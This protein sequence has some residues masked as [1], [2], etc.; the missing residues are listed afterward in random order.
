[1]FFSLLKKAFRF[2]FIAL[3]S[4]T[5][6]LTWTPASLGQFPF[7]SPSVAQGIPQ[8]PRWAPNKAQPCGNFWCSEV[9]FYGNNKIRGGL[10]LGAFIRNPDNPQKTPQETAFDLEQRAR[11]VQ[12]IFEEMF[13]K[14]VRSNPE[15]QVSEQKDWQFWWFRKEKPLH[16]LTPD[17]AVGTQ[18]RQ[19]VVFVPAQEE[20][21]L[22][23]QTI[24]T[25][26][27]IEARV[28]AKTIPE[29]AENWREELRQA[30][31][32]VLW[33]RELDLRYP[34]LRTA[35]V[36]A[37]ALIAFILIKIILFLG[38]FFRRWNKSL[39]QGLENLTNSL[40]VEPEAVSVG[41]IIKSPW[42]NVPLQFWRLLL[43]LDCLAAMLFLGESPER[44]ETQAASDEP[45]SE[46]PLGTVPSRL[47]SPF[48]FLRLMAQWQIPAP[49]L[50][51][52]SLQN[53]F[54]LKQQRNLSGLLVR[55]SW[56][57]IFSLILM[58]L[59][60]IVALFRPSRFLI[61]L[62]FEKIYLLP[63]IWI[64]MV[65]ADEVTNFFTDYA[66]N[67]WAKDGQEQEPNSN[68]Y[69][70]R[71][72]TYSKALAKGTTILFTIVGIVLTLGV[73]GLN[74][75]VL[76]G[77]G[78]SA[79]VLAYLSRN[80][81]EDMINGVLILATDRYA[82]GDVIDV[83]EGFA[84]FVEDMNLYVTSLRNRDG[85]VLVIP[86]GTISRVINMTKN[87]SRVNLTLRISWNADVRKAF[88]IMRQVA[89]TML[90][91]PEWQELMI[92]PVE[93]LGVDELSHDGI[94]IGLLVKTPPLKQWLVG[95]ELRLRVK[96]ALDEAGISLG[97]PQREVAL[98]QPY[99]HTRENNRHELFGEVGED[100]KESQEF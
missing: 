33:G 58:A 49:M 38:G 17:I 54:L 67:S 61:N 24:V 96:E 76:A 55:I 100:E 79:A 32:Q 20:L 47:R 25:V 46:T 57:A 18:N 22:V 9:N 42:E 26:T 35:L 40:V 16:P 13:R 71:A 80:V 83:G 7:L 37:I 19:T 85:Q 65:L 81:L 31:S 73:I 62:F 77:A 97:V 2:I 51:K 66:I 41:D 91:E 84:G 74:P 92:Q 28:N 1:M 98:T 30:M 29:L 48:Q 53:Q 72:N 36:G 14:I 43:E 39:K 52:V 50:P 90:S 86:N 88:E 93:I 11:F 34:W 78:A 12:N 68:R 64:G 95:R 75:S 6:T 15:S 10:T 3:L 99:A 8:S 59:G 82:V 87:W 94:L 63:L 5:L 27:E 4:F 69:T 70:L 45:K 21:G 44:D 23:Q 89:E 56:L 60:L